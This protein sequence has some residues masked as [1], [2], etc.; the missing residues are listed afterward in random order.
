MAIR[1]YLA[2]GSDSALSVER[3]ESIILGKA[4]ELYDSASNGNRQRG[5]MRRANEM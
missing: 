4:M 5:A 1:L 2:S 3:S